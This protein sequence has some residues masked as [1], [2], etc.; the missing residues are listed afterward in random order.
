MIGRFQPKLLS[1]LLIG[2]LTI[3]LTKL[4]GVFF[5]NEVSA[6]ERIS[7]LLMSVHNAPIPFV[8]LD[9]HK[10]LVYELWLGNFSSGDAVVEEVEVLGDSAV[11]ATLNTLSLRLLK[12]KTAYLS[13]S[14]CLLLNELSTSAWL[15]SAVGKV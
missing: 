1:W 6:A 10:H 14:F 11:L 15:A 9:G 13:T 12:F 2:V 5:I 3:T 7:P 4:P 8:G